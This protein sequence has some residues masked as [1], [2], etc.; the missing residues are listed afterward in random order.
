MHSLAVA[1]AGMVATLTAGPAA[2]GQPESGEGLGF[3]VIVGAL[4]VW[5]VGYWISLRIHPYTACR[6]CK[7]G[8]R[9]RGRFFSRSFGPCRSCKGTGRQLRLGARLFQMNRS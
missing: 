6:S 2:P 8:A 3:V 9:R 5:G 7:G 1:V 4:L